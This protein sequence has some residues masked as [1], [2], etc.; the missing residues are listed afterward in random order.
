MF[1]RLLIPILLTFSILAIIFKPLDR[2]P[3]RENEYYK[4]TISSFDLI[5][6][7]HINS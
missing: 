1:K 2:S 4:N 3:L 6:E 7:S 5:K